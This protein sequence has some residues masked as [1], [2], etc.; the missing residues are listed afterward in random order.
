MLV[1]LEGA[2][3]GEAGTV[4]RAAVI[5]VAV[6]LS[7]S[8][9]RAGALESAFEG[10]L[11]RGLSLPVGRVGALERALEGALERG[12]LIAFARAPAGV[13][14]KVL[15]R[16]SAMLLVETAEGGFERALGK[17]FG[18]D[19]GTAAEGGSEDDFV[20]LGESGKCRAAIDLYLYPVLLTLSTEGGVTIDPTLVWGECPP[21]AGFGSDLD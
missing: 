19:L 4:A 14:D 18:E 15:R 16:E 7:P 11:E 17:A 12:L 5:G 3:L 13:A 10:A 8:V 6:V 20:V 1:G 2:T 21:A 9:G